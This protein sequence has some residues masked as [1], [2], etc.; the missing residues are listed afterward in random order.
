MT[1]SSDFYSLRF[2][3]TLALLAAALLVVV[4]GGGSSLAQGAPATVRAPRFEPPPAVDGSLTDPVWKKGPWL[5][6]FLV[7]DPAGRPAKEKTHFKVGIDDQYLYVGA[8]LE[9]PKGTEVIR[10]VTERDGPVWRDDAIELT[11]HPVP[12]MDQYVHVVVNAAGV[13][14]DALRVQGGNLADA[15]VDLSVQAATRISDGSW[16]VELAIP[17]AELGLTR[18]ASRN[19]T[20]NVARSSRAGGKAE[21]SSYARMTGDLHKPHQFVPLELEALDVSPFLWT[22]ASQGDSRVIEEDGRLM[23]ET[24]VLVGNRTDR[25]AFFE[26][27]FAVRQDQRA[28]G[29]VTVPR[30]LDAGASRL[31]R[32]RIP[33]EGEGNAVVDLVLR[34]PA[35]RAALARLRYPVQVHYTPL[36]LT[37]TAP[38]Y[39]NT[40]YATQ[41]PEAVRGRLEINLPAERLEGGELE[42]RL[43]NAQG[44]VVGQS[45]AL[46]P[47]TAVD[48]EIPL[49][50]DWPEGAYRVRAVWKDSGKTSEA[51]AD[52]FRVG[53]PPAGGR[54]V[55]LN[56]N[57][58]TLVDGK[59]FLPNGAMMV[60]PREDLRTVAAQGYT[61]VMEYTFFYWDDAAKQAWLDHLQ[62]LGLMAVIYPY[63]KPEMS[64]GAALHEPLRDDELAQIRELILRWKDHPALLAWYLADEPELHSTLPERLRQLDRICRETDPYHPTIVLNNTPGGID[65]YGEFCDIL[66]PNP[67]PGFYQGGGARRSIEYAYSL[68]RHAALARG[69]N[70]AVW[71]TPQAFSWAD[72]RT[73]RANERPPDFRDLRSMYYQGVIAGSKGFI[74]YAYQHGRRHPSIRLG[75]GCLARELDAL[76][77]GILAPEEAAEFS[78][79]DGVLHS[80]RRSGDAA[81]LFVVNVSDAE[82]DFSATVPAGAWLVVSENRKISLEDGRLRD[83]LPPLAVRIYTTDPDAAH[84]L[85][86][87]KAERLI[88]E[89]PVL[90]NPDAPLPKEEQAGLPPSP[91]ASKP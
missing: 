42:V 51:V 23:L 2:R 50:A 81:Y 19:W 32:V 76:K 38:S 15:T 13:V 20:I 30:G 7:T 29:G 88:A 57:K 80:L 10:Q 46:P 24:Q 60:R 4:P 40:F 84:G 55:R 22:L 89:A 85:D 39:R 82:R 48:F 5:S 56:E 31:Q 52:L 26:L 70:R 44:A 37:L 69:G 49:S 91:S 83:S 12:A 64:K 58:V 43:E 53:S 78:A 36:R 54:E 71:M 8:L 25:Y 18:E 14:Y 59:P 27:D 66:M 73:E 62:E 41:K 72:V 45:R 67:F 47:A 16:S 65:T 74:P 6:G 63:P 33:V 1:L 61:A 77:N 9:G 21:V 3:G 35:S 90:A 86:L 11:L 75:L 87:E 28:L 68:V 17:L 79:A 34:D